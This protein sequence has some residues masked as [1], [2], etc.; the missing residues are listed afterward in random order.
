MDNTIICNGIH[1][2]TFL[3]FINTHTICLVHMYIQL[4]TYSHIIYHFQENTGQTRGP[5]GLDLNVE[6]AWMQGITGEG[7]IV[8]IVDDGQLDCRIHGMI[9]YQCRI[10]MHEGELI[11]CAFGK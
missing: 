1:C 6:P 11:L 9:I 3:K 7:V 8:G 4:V 2:S 5:S 10:I